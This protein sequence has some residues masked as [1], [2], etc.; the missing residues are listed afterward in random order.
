MLQ[1]SAVG[2]LLSGQKFWKYSR[3]R[4][5]GSLWGPFHSRG[6]HWKQTAAY[7]N[8]KTSWSST[9]CWRSNASATCHRRRSACSDKESTSSEVL[10]LLSNYHQTHPILLPHIFLLRPHLFL[11]VK[12][13]YL[14]AILVLLTK[15]WQSH[16]LI[17]EYSMRTLMLTKANLMNVYLTR[18]LHQICLI[19][20]IH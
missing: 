1:V 4:I 15:Y 14:L 9:H 13:D 3:P 20:L 7:C 5:Q 18:L 16:L 2:G 19:R 11:T 17:L 8:T 12:G 6:F 10:Q